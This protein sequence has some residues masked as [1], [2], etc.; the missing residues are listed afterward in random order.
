MCYML[1]TRPGRRNAPL[2]RMTIKAV[3]A[4]VAIT[5]KI[6]E[7]LTPDLHRNHTIH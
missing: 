1:W 2:T 4:I 6:A 5:L 3:I 7:K